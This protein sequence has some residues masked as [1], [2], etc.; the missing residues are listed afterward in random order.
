M[1]I[2]LSILQTCQH[3]SIFIWNWDDSWSPKCLFL[4]QKEENGTKISNDML[5]CFTMEFPIERAFWHPTC[6]TL[7]NIL[8]LVS[9]T[10]KLNFSFVLCALLGLQFVFITFCQTLSCANQQISWCPHQCWPGLLQQGEY[11]HY[12]VGMC[13]GLEPWRRS[14]KGVLHSSFS[15]AGHCS[16]KMQQNVQIEGF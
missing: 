12:T 11:P 14:G 5:K 9:L 4:L 3:F 10:G 8:F 15:Q 13:S 2:R 16:G 7:W 6:I 1:R